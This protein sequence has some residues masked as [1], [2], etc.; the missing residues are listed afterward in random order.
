ML[1]AGVL[2]DRIG[3][4]DPD[5]SDFSG[6]STAVSGGVSVDC[7]RLCLLSA[8]RKERFY[9]YCRLEISEGSAGNPAEIVPHEGIR[10][11]GGS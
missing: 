8:L 2:R 7:L 3:R 1:A 9:E 10:S 6:R 11:S 4:R 5:C